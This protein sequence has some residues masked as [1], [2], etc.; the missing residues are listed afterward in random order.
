MGIRPLE[1]RDM[2][3]A[4]FIAHVAMEFDEINEGIFREK[5]IEA[6]D[7]APELA[8]A[9]EEDGQLAGFAQGALGKKPGGDGKLVGYIRLMSVDPARRQK[10]IGSALLTELEG[11]LKAR[12]CAV[13]SIMDCPQNYFMPGVDFRYTPAFCFLEKHGYHKV[14]ENHN[15]ICDIGPEFYPELDGQ[16]ESLAKEGLEIRRARHGDEE[17]VHAFLEANWPGWHDEAEG[18][19]ANDPISLYIGTYEGRTIAFSGYQGNNHALN[20]FGPMGT[21]PVLR[22]KGIGGIVLKLCLRDLALQGWRKAIIPWVGPVRFYSKMCG[23]R[24]DRCFYVFR[25]DL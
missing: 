4:T 13:V 25:K 19:F 16:I 18:A 20:W 6:R 9:Y 21:L 24:L 2:V 12:G 23:A 3:R 17:S 14:W 10:G 11:R 5:T 1:E 15:L 7:F 22:G 8:L